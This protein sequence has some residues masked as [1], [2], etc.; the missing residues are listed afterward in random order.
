MVADDL[1]RL[2]LHGTQAED[3][4]SLVDPAAKDVPDRADQPVEVIGGGVGGLINMLMSRHINILI[5]CAGH[6]LNTAF[7]PKTWGIATIPR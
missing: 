6:P 1:Q 2:A 5:S 4:Q 3:A 7:V